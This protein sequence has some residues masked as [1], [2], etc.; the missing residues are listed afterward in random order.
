MLSIVFLLEIVLMSYQVYFEYKGGSR[1]HRLKTNIRTKVE[2][3]LN[4]MLSDKETL[5]MA[6]KIVVRYGSKVILE[7]KTSLPSSTLKKRIK[8]PAGGAPKKIPNAVTATF[9]IP[10]GVRSWLTEHGNGKMNEGLRKLLLE[11]GVKELEQAYKLK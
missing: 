5:G 2:S 8:W 3:H 1:S 6:E 11:S 4:E 9:Y 7:A 10:D